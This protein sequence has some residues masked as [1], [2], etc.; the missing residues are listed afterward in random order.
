MKEI[1]KTTP[2][3][4]ILELGKAC[5]R[6]G[7]C[8]IYGT[9]FL[10]KGDIERIAWFLKI[11]KK[12]LI[13]N[14]L[15]PV[16]KF[17]KTLYRPLAIKNKK[18]YGTCIFFNTDLGCTIHPVKPLQCKISTCDEYG[19]DISVWFTLNYFVNPRDPESIRQWALY[20]LSGG[21][22]IQGGAL[23]ELVPNASILRKILRYE[24]LK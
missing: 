6:C 2:L 15:E 11:S 18:A 24:I 20:L 13:K 19:E 9:G 10:T 21:K 8:C 16:T 23:R 7:H 22:N 14:C 3:R 17:N 5:K 1:K 4:K 12:E